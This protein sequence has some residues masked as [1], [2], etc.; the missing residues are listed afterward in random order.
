RTVFRAVFS[1]LHTAYRILLTPFPVL[2]SAYCLLLTVFPLL[3]TAYC[4]LLTPVRASDKPFISPT[5]W[6]GT[7]LIEIPTARV[8]Q[9]NSVRAGFG[10][11]D[12]YRYYYGAVSPLKGLEFNLRITEFIDIEFEDQSTAKDK[13]FDVKYQFLPEGKYTPAFAIGFNDP[14]GTRL[15]PSQYIAASKQIYPFDFTIGFGNGRFGDEPLPEQGEGFKLEIFSDTGDWLRDSNFFGGIQFAPSEKFAM[16]VEYSPIKFDEQTR[17]P[18]QKEH[19]RDPV[20]SQFNFGIRYKPVEWFEVDLSYQRGEEI[21]VNASLAF[22]IGNPLLPIYDPPYRED[23]AFTLDP[24]AARIERALYASG[25]SDIGVLMEDDALWIQAQNDKYYFDATAID[26]ILRLIIDR[27]PPGV[28]KIHIILT[29]NG[30]PQIA[31]HT[32]RA[33][34]VDFQDNRLSVNEL[35]HL[36]DVKTDTTRGPDVQTTYSKRLFYG[37]KPSFETFLNDPSGFFKYRLGLSGW[38]GYNPWKGATLISSVEGYPVNNISTSNEPLSI[39]VRSDIVLYKKE[40]VALGRLLIDQIYKA[41]HEIYGKLSAGLLEIEYAG[42][43]AE[44]AKP[45]L[46]G[47]VLLGLSGSIVK[48]REAGQPF[49][50]KRDDVKDYYTT[51]FFNTRVNVP[52]MDIAV[53]L[54]AGRFLAG[55]PGVRFTVSKFINGIILTAW[56]SI[57]DTS[58]FTDSYNDGYND[59]GISVSIPLRMLLGGDSKTVFHYSLSP[60]TRDTG[61]D[62]DHYGTLFDFIGR[63]VNILIDKDVQMIYR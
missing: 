62:I 20:S 18:A 11:A 25:F 42:V 40:D 54:K 39:P 29:E 45:V 37:L 22:D 26:T 52:E 3:L 59:K 30:I 15:Y 5:N 49:K 10:Q 38:T 60:W 31:F 4:L 55:D 35:Y 50:L 33:D 56:Y 8:M 2:P 13:A 46:S 51:A 24:A 41:D 36:A 27:V 34:V 48:K 7:G 1:F 17:D 61:Q 32:G 16:M 9:E 43:D 44:V 14:H 23:P 28:E 53:D 21:G 6:G 58:D 19:F 63:K 57:T 47:R 12:P